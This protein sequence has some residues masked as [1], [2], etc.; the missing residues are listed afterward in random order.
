MSASGS[1]NILSSSSSEG[2]DVFR[3]E[4]SAAVH[5]I[6]SGFYGLRPR[7]EKPASG[8]GSSSSS[9]P[10]DHNELCPQ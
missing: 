7:K 8:S 5:K 2:E 6:S 9:V 10:D 1:E 4:V 3:K